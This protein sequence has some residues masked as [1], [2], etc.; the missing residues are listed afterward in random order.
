MSVARSTLAVLWFGLLGAPLAWTLQLWLSYGAAEAACAPGA[1]GTLLDDTSDVSVAIIGV[2]AA[3][4][5]A[6]ALG[7]ALRSA[8]R[9][10]GD[11]GAPSY[12][13]FMAITGTG[14]SALFLATIVLGLVP[15]LALDPC[16]GR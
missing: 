10:S 1:S 9:V 16:T 11:D 15:L 14:V 4:V 6:L 8:T 2:I 5:A 13:R 3:V 7:A 12:V